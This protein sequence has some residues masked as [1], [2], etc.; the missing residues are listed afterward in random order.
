MGIVAIHYYN[1]W[2]YLYLQS[3]LDMV[4]FSYL[5]KRIDAGESFRMTDIHRWC[6]V[7]KIKYK[8]KF[9]YRKD[10]PVKANL[11]NFYSY[12]RSKIEK[13]YFNKLFFEWYMVII[14][15][16]IGKLPFSIRRIPWKTRKTDGWKCTARAMDI[17]IKRFPPSSSKE[18][19]LKKQASLLM[20]E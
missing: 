20:T 17:T 9:V 11:W 19:G 7:Q 10:F 13:I 1:V 5:S 4:K 8:T 12:I 2:F 16:H 3:E 6:A 14:Y 18:N 15:S